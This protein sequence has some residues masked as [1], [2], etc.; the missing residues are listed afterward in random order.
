MSP[1]K[2][3]GPGNRAHLPGLTSDLN[4]NSELRTD[5]TSQHSF[6]YLN[7]Q[8]G[9]TTVTALLDTGSSINIISRQFYEIIPDGC[10]MD[11]QPSDD[12]IVLADNFSVSVYGTAR[13]HF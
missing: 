8:I 10:K 11:F 1:V 13:V 4:D 2:Q 6:M 3:E 7:C 12:Q 9:H 5:F